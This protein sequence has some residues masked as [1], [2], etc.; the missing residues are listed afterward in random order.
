[1]DLALEL[2]DDPA[3]RHVLLNHLPI[4]G[5]AVAWLVLAWA[6]IEQRWSSLC[7]GLLL[8]LSMSGSA[9]W[10]MSAG[11]EA[12]PFVYDALDGAGRD[13]LDHHTH[14]ADRWGRLLIANAIV[15]ALALA[16]GFFR[17]RLR[18]PAAAVVL[19]STL[20]GLVA[21]FVIAEAGGKI[22]HPEFRLS[23]PPVHDSP[24][25]IR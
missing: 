11:D 22:R 5:L 13:W 23:D 24:G 1:M 9:L 25:R 10:V 3:Y 20:A 21:V 12:Y 14:L 7:C 15:A 16:A 19:V 18:T 8:V 17:E 6:L 4:T 2:L